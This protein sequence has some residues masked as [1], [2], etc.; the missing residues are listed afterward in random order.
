MLEVLAGEDGFDYRQRAPRIH[1]YT[2][3]IEDGAGGLRIG[4]VKEGFGVPG[5]SDAEVDAKVRKAAQ[6]FA[7]L[8]AT[9]EETSIPQHLSHFVGYWPIFLDGA[10]TRCFFEEGVTT[11]QK[12]LYV[13]S[14]SERLA[15]WRA[16]ADELA[17][18]VKAIMILSCYLQT[19]IRQPPLCESIKS[20]PPVAR[21]L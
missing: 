19:Q 8:G 12:T 11:G 6:R 16:R 7:E 17:H 9:V 21:G 20:S 3:G 18:T 1:A 13:T 4:I 5:V 14:A 10:I 15:G 2:K